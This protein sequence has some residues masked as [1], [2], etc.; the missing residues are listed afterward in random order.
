MR[1][2]IVI[3]L[4][5]GFTFG[6]KKFALV[7]IPEITQ[8]KMTLLIK[9]GFDLNSHYYSDKAF[10]LLSNWLNLGSNAWKMELSLLYKKTT[11][12]NP[13]LTDFLQQEGIEAIWT[14][15]QINVP[16][17]F[18][19]TEQFHRWFDGLKTIRLLKY[20]TLIT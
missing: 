11:T 8:N 13:S 14:N 9:N 19:F 4:F 1:I 5:I 15:L 10:H 12:I 7:Y 3:F 2:I 20:F 18:H 16:S 17:E 6:I